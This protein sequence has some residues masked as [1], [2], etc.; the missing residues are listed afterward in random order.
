MTSVVNENEGVFLPSPVVIDVRPQTTEQLF[1][2]L[3][4]GIFNDLDVLFSAAHLDNAIFDIFGVGFDLRDVLEAV[5]SFIGTHMAI[6]VVLNDDPLEVVW[7]DVIFN[8]RNLR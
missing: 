1:E 5:V 2:H 3:E 4:V 8:H 6:F 7:P